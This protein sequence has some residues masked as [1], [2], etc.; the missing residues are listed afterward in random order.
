MIQY[1]HADL[2]DRAYVTLGLAIRAI[3]FQIPH[4]LECGSVDV[5]PAVLS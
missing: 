4:D 1:Y 2:T 3:L 5:G